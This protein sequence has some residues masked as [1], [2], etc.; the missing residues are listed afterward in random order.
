MVSILCSSEV[1][2][3]NLKKL[4]FVIKGLKSFMFAQTPS[5]YGIRSTFEVSIIFSG[6]L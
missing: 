1:R 2:Q 6:L 5:V 4:R 3:S